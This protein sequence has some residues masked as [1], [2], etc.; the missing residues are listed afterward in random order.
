MNE[1][2]KIDFNVVKKAIY[3]RINLAKQNINI[4][5][6]EIKKKK[7]SQNPL[8]T[9]IELEEYKKS[10]VEKEKQ[11]QLICKEFEML[12]QKI[13]RY[14]TISKESNNDSNWDYRKR[15]WEIR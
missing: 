7:S 9:G 2:L 4:L 11:E 14:A 12:E 8:L 3:E 6:E 13:I 10:L 1:I 15:N 5:S